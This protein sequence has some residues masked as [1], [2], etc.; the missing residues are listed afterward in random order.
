MPLRA[1][2]VGWDSTFRASR[3][4]VQWAALIAIGLFFA[5]SAAAEQSVLTLCDAGSSCYADGDNDCGCEACDGCDGCSECCDA[6][7]GGCCAGCCS[8]CAGDCCGDCCDRLFGH[9][10][11][12]PD[13]SDA[14][15]KS[16][17]DKHAPAGIMGDHVHHKGE[18][19]FEYKYM[20][21][22]MEDNR[23]GKTTVPDAAAFG[24]DGTNVLATPTQMTMEMHMLHIM[25]GLTDSVT[26]YAMPI[27]NSLTM[28][29]LRNT[30]FGP[31]PPLAGLPF[32]THNSGFAD[33]SLGALWQFHETACSQWVLD[34]G[35]SLPTGDI[36][37]TTRIPT[38]G[39]LPQELPYPMR[40]GSGTF[41]FRPA[42]TYKRFFC[43]GSFG[44]Q[45]QGNIPAG[46][47]A[48]QYSVG[49]MFRLNAWYAH[50][51]QDW[52]AFSFRVEGM[53]KNNYDGADPD[54]PQFIISTNRP[55]MRGGE[56]LR[57]GYGA[58]L[59][60]KGGNLINGEIVH[61]VYQYVD[62]IQLEDDWRFIISWSK[63]F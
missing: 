41:N 44:A 57:F 43:R 56:W 58:M 60:L 15:R 5:R 21:M 63:A 9:H 53:W 37:R 39:L 10:W 19:M 20:N 11:I 48:E 27:W 18:W 45:F 3:I 24:Y 23:I 8:D 35:F 36:D 33:L 29:H 42:V 6:G 25:Y 28:D 47:N 14:K 59:L 34:F 13:L 62:G 16:L 54:L 49:E 12:I 51:V 31:N 50:L 30:P 32:T 26:L 17:A 55:D 46:R 7:C 40:L 38:G 22:Y 1:P 52:L 2:L 4:A 61:P